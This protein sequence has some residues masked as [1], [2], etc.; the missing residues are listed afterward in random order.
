MGFQK[1]H[2]RN[3]GKNNPMF[4]TISPRK[5]VIFSI[6]TRKKMSESHKGEKHHLFGKKHK[7]ET[8]Q[9]MSE[10]RKGKFS[11]EKSHFWKGGI[12]KIKYTQ[13][14]TETLKRS[15]RERDKYICQLCNK[16]Q[17]KKAHHV[18]HINYDKKNCSPSNLITL[19][20]NCHGRM[21]TNIE[22]WKEILKNI[23]KKYE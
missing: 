21:A 1:G 17:E 23:I 8:I 13:D 6:K 11:G 16:P 7:K 9:K 19:C 22:Y 14:W 4:G 12:C 15:I 3:N 18:H 5:G 20:C 2:T 10:W